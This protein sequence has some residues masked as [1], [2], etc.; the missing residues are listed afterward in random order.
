M[1]AREPVRALAKAQVLAKV[2]GPEWAQALA[3]EPVQ[4]RVRV[5]ALGPEQ[6]QAQAW[7]LGLE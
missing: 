2:R 4:V 1:Q 7:E 3:W 6:A 5:Q